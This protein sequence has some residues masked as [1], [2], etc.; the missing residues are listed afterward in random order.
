[1]LFSKDK[2]EIS[3]APESSLAFMFCTTALLL[4]VAIKLC[5]TR[6]GE[7]AG[8]GLQQ[9]PPQGQFRA[10]VGVA[11]QEDRRTAFLSPKP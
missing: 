3:T 1:M 4:K 10:S 5:K 2:S 6:M 11:H 8:L 9:C 7:S